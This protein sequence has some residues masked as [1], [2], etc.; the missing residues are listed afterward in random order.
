MRLWL[1]VCLVLLASPLMAESWLDERGDY[2]EHV[3]VKFGLV[4]A[5]SGGL[6]DT[7]ASR[8]FNEA[9]TLVLAV[10]RAVKRLTTI[11]T[12][13]YENTY[14][15]DST[16]IDIE[17]VWLD[18]AGVVKPMKF[19]PV[20]NWHDQFHGNTDGT[21]N[22][23]LSRS[24]YY[25]YTDSLIFI[26]PT[27]SQTRI[28]TLNILGWHRLPDVDTVT[29]PTVIPEMYRLA[30]VYHMCWNQARARG[31]PREASFEREFSLALGQIRLKLGIGG[32]VES[33]ADN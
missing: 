26:F 8:L 25:D 4:T 24:S 33:P 18:S 12:S 15:L 28:D 14:E 6:S 29:A 10:N 27:P 1:V 16:L 3:R 32:L 11:P 7:V 20:K 19:L 9:T 22:P 30:I 17:T 21:P 2:Y 5:S 23:L 13:I 31:D